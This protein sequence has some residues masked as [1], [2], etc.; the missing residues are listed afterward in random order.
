MDWNVQSC[1]HCTSALK[2]VPN[3]FLKT[4][5]AHDLCLHLGESL[6]NCRTL[7]SKDSVCCCD[8]TKKNK[9]VLRCLVSNLYV[10]PLFFNR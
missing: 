7:V 4:V 5:M 1:L 3:N 10:F 6:L 9:C 8:G 2:L